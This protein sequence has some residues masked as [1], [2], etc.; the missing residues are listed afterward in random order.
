MLASVLVLPGLFNSG[1]QH[2]QSLWCSK[3]P[4]YHRL[5][6]EDWETP[7]CSDW[8]RTLAAAISKID[9]PLVLAGHSTACATVAH[10]AAQHGDGAG[11]VAAAFLVGP[12]DTEAP[13]YPVGPT[14][15]SPMPLSKLP[16]P[17]VVVA[18][19]DDPYVTLERAMLFASSWGSRLIT[20]AGAGHINAAAGFGPWPE[21]EKWLEELR[22]TD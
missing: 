3:H 18:S 17:S 13:T 11:R 4:D 2:W 9:R 12:S 1:P 6:Q 14:G 19:T 8:V 22:R 7:R 20:L 21:G 15:F 10:Y 16:F 5:E